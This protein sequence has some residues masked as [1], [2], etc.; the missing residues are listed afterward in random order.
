[1]I[2]IIFFLALGGVIFSLF[3]SKNQ[4]DNNIIKNG[5]MNILTFILLFIVYYV[6]IAIISMIPLYLISSNSNSGS[7]SGLWAVSIFLG[8]GLAPILSLITTIRLSKK[9]KNIETMEQIND[10]TI[11]KKNKKNPIIIIAIAIVSFIGIGIILLTIFNFKTPTSTT[12]LYEIIYYDELIPGSRYVI[13]IHDNNKVEIATTHFCSAIDCSPKTEKEKFNYSKDNINKLKTFINDNFSKSYIELHEYELTEHQKE[14]IQGLLLGEY[15]F[16]ANVEE[17]KYKIEYSKSDDL[18]YNIYFKNDKSILV[19]KLK[20]NSDYD[21]VNVDT[22]SLNFSQKN[23]NI[24]LDYIEKEV[25]KQN[26]NIIYKYSTLQKDE[27]NMFN[28][29]VDNNET[30]L[31][32]IEDEAKLSYTISYN[33]IDCPTPT[34]YLYSDNTYEYYYTFGTDNEKLIPK[35][36]TYN[37]DIMKIINN[38]NKYEENSFGPY[39]IKEENG[40]S[41]T[42]YNTNS[43]LQEF[44][45]SLNITLEKCLEQQ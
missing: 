4:N 25:K 18:S 39:S 11:I 30:Y 5:I 44:L 33:G 26:S 7:D 19:K 41:Y 31:N 42:T 24:L 17:Y 35:T 16:E 37:Y 23:K 38:I 12:I 28:S 10:N 40:K 9:K 1:M 22:Y 20:I 29:I 13:N 15:F 2:I 6:V 34:L 43:E 3:K 36:G 21:I 27:I 45:S 14:V 32:N 8:M